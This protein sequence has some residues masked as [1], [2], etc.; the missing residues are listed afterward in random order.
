MHVNNENK[1]G[2]ENITN[3]AKTRRI[4]IYTMSLSMSKKT[5]F[6]LIISSL[7]FY[8]AN[9]QGAKII[10]GE[11]DVFTNLE[12][13]DCSSSKAECFNKNCTYCQCKKGT[14]VQARGSYGECVKNKY[15]AYV[16]CKLF[17]VA[18]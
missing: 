16:A 11:K 7:T 8:Q 10:R 17:D 1:V 9:S 4:K 3:L 2:Q 13:D 12:E 5:Y 14:F 15:L 6:I 18:I